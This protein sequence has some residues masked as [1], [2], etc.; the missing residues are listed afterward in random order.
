VA[1]R[2]RAAVAAAPQP[3]HVFILDSN[4]ISDI[5]YSAARVLGELAGELRQAG[6]R[7]GVARAS[8]LVRDSLKLSGVLS[9]IG[10]ERLFPSV[11]DAVTALT[12]EP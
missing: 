4:G 9:I 12:R 3:V 11:E 10:A 7:I 1:G 2:I 6:L 5:D 8:H